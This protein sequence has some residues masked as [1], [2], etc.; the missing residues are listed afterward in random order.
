LIKLLEKETS[1]NLNTVLVSTAMGPFESNVYF[2]HRA[3]NGAGTNEGMLTEAVIGRGPAEL[4]AMRQAYHTRYK[5]NLDTEIRGDLSL[6]TQELF[7]MALSGRRPEEWVQP[8]PQQIQAEMNALYS[9]TKKRIGKDETTVSRVLT[10]TNDAQL[11][12]IAYEYG[13]LHGDLIKMLKSEFSGHMRD[14]FVYLVEG[15]LDKPKRDATLLEASMKGIGTKDDLLI[16]RVVRVHW[17]PQHLVNVKAA[18]RNLY[19]KDLAER[20]RGETSGYY[21]DMLLDLVK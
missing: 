20:I 11:R 21:R 12:A 4:A 14:V 9:A 10:A 19:G 8:V 7:E 15:A 13:K 3:T 17:D 6:K 5:K 1:G 2:A 16:Q 18:F